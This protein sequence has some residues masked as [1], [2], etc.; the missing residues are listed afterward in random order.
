VSYRRYWV[1]GKR[2]LRDRLRREGLRPRVLANREGDGVDGGQDLLGARRGAAHS[3]TQG[4]GNESI[5][6]LLSYREDTEGKGA[7]VGQKRQKT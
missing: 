5:D 6:S 7:E 4:K 3:N 1:S 2:G